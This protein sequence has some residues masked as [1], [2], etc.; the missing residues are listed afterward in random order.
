MTDSDRESLI[1]AAYDQFVN[2]TSEHGRAQHWRDMCYHVRL[3]SPEQVLKMETERRISAKFSPL[4]TYDSYNSHDHG[5]RGCK[6][7]KAHSP[8]IT[9]RECGYT[10]REFVT[11]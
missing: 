5:M 8:G 10:T 6:Y 7:A 3:R 4:F 9:C 2:A 1:D 11:S